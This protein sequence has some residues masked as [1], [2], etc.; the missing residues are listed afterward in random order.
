MNLVSSLIT[1]VISTIGL[2]LNLKLEK[3]TIKYPR[4]EL[5]GHFNLFIWI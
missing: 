4:N 3:S 1:L 5:Y 2:V